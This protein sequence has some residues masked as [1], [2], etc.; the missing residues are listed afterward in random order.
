M[1]SVVA[2]AYQRVVEE[3]K[4]SLFKSYKREYRDGEQK[5]DFIYVKDAVEVVLF[6][7]DH[8]EINGIF[9]V[10]TGKA[11]TW[12]D[13]ADALFKAVGKKTQVD[14]V[15]M[16]DGLKDRYQYFTQADMSRLRE[17]GFK[18]PFTELEEAVSDYSQYLKDH[19][20]L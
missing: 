11:R 8:P 12:I 4:I 17:K 18:K 3:G 5:R 16:P 6:F 10:G 14:F 19:S 9:N 7:F 20:H 13:L 2:K 1:Q 15:E